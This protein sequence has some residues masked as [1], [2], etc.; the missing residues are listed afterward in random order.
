MKKFELFCWSLALIFCLVTGYI[1]LHASEVQAPILTILVFTFLLGYL[2]PKRAWLWAIVLSLSIPLSF[3]IPPLLG[4]PT[5]YQPSPNI[6][7]TLIALIPA[8]IG[9]Y[10]GVLFRILTLRPRNE[11]S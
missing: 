7:A 2:H 5:P 11:R 9:T 6:F 4:Y 10:A 3:V 1:N 8:F